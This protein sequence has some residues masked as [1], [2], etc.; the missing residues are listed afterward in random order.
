MIF[1]DILCTSLEGFY[2][3][4]LWWGLAQLFSDSYF[5]LRTIH[6]PNLDMCLSPC[7]NLLWI[8]MGNQWIIVDNHHICWLI[9]PPPGWYNQSSNGRCR[10]GFIA[11]MNGLCYP[12]PNCSPGRSRMVMAWPG[13]RWL[14]DAEYQWH[15]DTNPH[16]CDTSPGARLMPGQKRFSNLW[17]VLCHVYLG[18]KHIEM[19]MI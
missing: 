4:W 16:P 2:D 19:L 15:Q 3:R 1:Y 10:A 14:I 17:H 8:I 7:G 11:F 12:W 5:D 6:L 18:S 9:K 13:A